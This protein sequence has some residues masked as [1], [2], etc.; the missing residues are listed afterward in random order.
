MNFRRLALS[1]LV[2]G[3]LVAGAAWLWRTELSM[4]VARRVAAS[5]IGT[6]LQATLPDGLHVGLC[7]AGSPFPDERRSGPCTVVIAGKHLLVF[8]AGSGSA[9]NI[10]KMGLVQGH[11]NAIFLTHFHSDHIDGLGE[12]LLQRWVST[13]HVAPVPLYGPAGVDAVV[14][15]ITQAY[16][17]DQRY[18]TA[19]HGEATVP[20]GGFGA[21]THPFDAGGGHATVVLKEGD[22]EV[23]AFEV[24][25][26]PIHPAVGYRIRYKNRSVVLSGDTV[27]SPVLQQES[28]GVDLLVHEALSLPLVQVLI[29]AAGQAGRANL[30]QIFKDI[31][32]YHATPEQ[33]AE[34]ARDA[35]VRYL[36]LNHI[37]PTLP[38]MPGIEKAFLGSA[39]DI[40][41]GPLRVGQD[42]DF[43]SLP[44]GSGEIN[45]SRLF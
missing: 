16:T 22:L 14:N 5:R 36:L 45:V 34:V 35:K 3:M 25:H 27:K 19:H 21:V 24:S 23:S 31:T 9:R 37:V 44:A 41:T 32:N 39:P 11:I 20:S 40:Y 8:D 43:I 33:A 42:G 10:G 4:A 1:A 18:R 17:Q 7:G 26:A 29:D 30:Q 28:A 15:G 12:L 13:R 38:P 2:L 6:D